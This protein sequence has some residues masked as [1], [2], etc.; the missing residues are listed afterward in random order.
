M[1][2]KIEYQEINTVIKESLKTFT[3]ICKEQSIQTE[4]KLDASLPEILIDKDQIRQALINFLSNAIDVMPNG[5]T[6]KISTSMEELNEVNYV[7]VEVADTGHGIPEE[8][9]SMIF[10]PFYSSKEIGVGT[11][12]GL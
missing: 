7:A 10:E 8:E 5:G 6:I 11:G 4:E 12:L 1:E 2:Y 3:E 9:L